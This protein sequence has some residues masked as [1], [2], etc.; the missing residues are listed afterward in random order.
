VTS[1]VSSRDD[2]TLLFSFAGPISINPLVHEKLPYD[3]ERDLVPIASA[4]D[5]FFAIAVSKSLGVDSMRAFVDL[6]RSQPDKFNWAATPGLPQYI[7]AALE[8]DAGIKMTQV[9][10]RDFA[11]AL[12]DFA[13]DRVQ[14]VVSSPS[15]L[16]PLVA[17]GT[18][19][20]LMVTNRERS[21]VAPDAPTAAEAGFPELL[22]EGVV[23]FYGW[24]DMSAALRERIAGDIAAVAAD[25]QIGARLRDVGVVVRSSTSAEFAAAIADQ[26]AKVRALVEIAKPQR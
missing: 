8:K 15:Y 25:P 12:Q 20:F 5:N 22:F 9:P 4:V 7:F 11:P 16:L 19:R 10:Y 6:A 2:H 21:P 1:F 18:A 24:R 3:P 13:K 17:A 14:V 23:G 26:K